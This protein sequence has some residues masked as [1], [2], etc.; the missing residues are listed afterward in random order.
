MWS[1]RHFPVIEVFGNT[2]WT[3]DQ[4]KTMFAM[5]NWHLGGMF[6]CVDLHF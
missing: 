5:I 6:T 1:C 4:K 2:M 3:S